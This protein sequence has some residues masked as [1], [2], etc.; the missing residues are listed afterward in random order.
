MKT[1]KK[2][3]AITLFLGLLLLVAPTQNHTL[4]TYRDTNGNYLTHRN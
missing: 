2:I 1:I 4:S 3:L